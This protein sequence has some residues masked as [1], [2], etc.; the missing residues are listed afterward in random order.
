MGLQPLQIFLIFQRGD[1]L[2]T[3]EFDVCRRQIV[4]Y[5][6]GPR[7]ERVKALTTTIVVFNLFYFPMKPLLLWIKWVFKHQYLKLLGPIFSKYQFLYP[8]EVV[9][10]RENVK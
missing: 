6:N 4:T 2:Y 10:A 3:S 5:I 1:R 7:A 8:L 9:E